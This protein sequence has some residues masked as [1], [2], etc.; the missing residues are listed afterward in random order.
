[1]LPRMT[2]VEGAQSQEPGGGIFGGAAVAD[3]VFVQMKGL[4]HADGVAIG[5]FFW[6]RHQLI[7]PDRYYGQ[8]RGR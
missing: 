2:V 7:G 6:L 5:R 1:M 4:A 3:V 8:T